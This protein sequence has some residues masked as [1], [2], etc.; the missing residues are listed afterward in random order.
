MGFIKVF[1]YNI[2]VMNKTKKIINNLFSLLKIAWDEDKKFLLG[3][4]ITSLF[5]ALLLFV[6]FFLYK[7]MIDQVFKSLV[8][9]EITFV[10]LIVGSYLI[11]EY[12]SRFFTN[13]L[14][15]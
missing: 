15:S 6:V 4:F 7:L 10:F 5:S 11:S 3:Y 1:Y 9:K 2:D 14:N 13:T 12:L 8:N